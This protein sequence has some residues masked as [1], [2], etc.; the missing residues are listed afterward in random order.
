MQRH[1]CDLHRAALASR[2]TIC[3]AHACARERRHRDDDGD[4][5]L[6]RRDEARSLRVIVPLPR[7]AA[8][9]P[10]ASRAR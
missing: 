6:V 5:S 8:P 4:S 3:N 1:R 7:P 10:E 9:R 2:R